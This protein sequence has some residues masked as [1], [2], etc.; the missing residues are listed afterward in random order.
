MQIKNNVL[1]VTTPL[2]LHHPQPEILKRRLR[3]KGYVRDRASL[4]GAPKSRRV[5]LVEMYFPRELR[6]QERLEVQPFFFAR[7][8]KK[9]IATRKRLLRAAFELQMLRQ[10]QED[11]R[12][13][14][15]LSLNKMKTLLKEMAKALLTQRNVK[16]AIKD[17]F[18]KLDDFQV[19]SS[20]IN[21]DINYFTS[22]S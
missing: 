4:P 12:K 22:K 17:G 6:K 19:T 10:Q 16:K 2:I 3:R 11:A 8:K 13:E 5:A 15:D 14:E 9:G 20:L 21:I 1:L 7:A 18:P